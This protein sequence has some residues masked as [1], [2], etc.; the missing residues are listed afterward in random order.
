VE[1][2]TAV[3]S[4]QAIQ[5]IGSFPLSEPSVIETGLDEARSRVVGTDIVAPDHVPPFSRSLVDGY[6]VKAKDTYGARETAPG[7]LIQTGDIRVGQVTDKVVGD[8]QAIYV[9]TGAMLPK[10]ADAV[11]MQ[12]Y[13]R[14]AADDSTDLEATKSLR[15]GENICFEGEDVKAGQVVFRQGKRLSPFDLGV[16]AALGITRIPVFREP[17]VGLISSGDEIVPP[18]VV[19]PPGMIRDINTFTVS[20]LLANHGC[21]VQF[22]GIARDTLEETADKMA[23]LKEC[24]MI[25]LSGGSSKGQADFVTAAIEYLG[26]RILFHGLNIKPGKPTIFGTL[27]NKPVFGLP[28]HPVSC[29]MVIVRFVLPLVQRLTGDRSSNPFS[30]VQGQLTTNIP[31]SYGIEEYVRVTLKKEDGVVAATPIFAKSSVISMLSKADGYIVI[32]EGKEGL[33][34]GEEVEVHSFA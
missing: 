24:D 27:W 7:L 18:D 34:A 16:L 28:G 17:L 33:E 5:I 8:G 13:V 25:L 31:S 9:A 32:E 15:V 20:N 30:A 6:A 10:G 29:A 11:L 14:K 19:P 4:I 1:F 23:A 12:E 3:T 22:A 2:L 26:G 21:R